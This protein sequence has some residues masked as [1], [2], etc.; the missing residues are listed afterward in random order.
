MSWISFFFPFLVLSRIQEET[1]GF[2]LHPFDLPRGPGLSVEPEETG[3]D[4][5]FASK[6]HSKMTTESS[7]SSADFYKLV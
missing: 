1:R 3:Q 7:K 2:H 6:D 4:T 5:P